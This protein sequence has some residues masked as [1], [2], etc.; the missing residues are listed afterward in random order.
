MLAHGTARRNRSRISRPCVLRPV[1]WASV[2]GH[3]RISCWRL[4]ARRPS[5]PGGL[6][7]FSLCS[8]AKR[9]RPTGSTGVAPPKLRGRAVFKC[10]FCQSF[11]AKV[12]LAPGKSGRQ[13]RRGQCDAG[14][15]CCLCRKTLPGRSASDPPAARGR[16]LSLL[17]SQQVKNGTTSFRKTV[18]AESRS[19]PSE[20]RPPPQHS[21]GRQA[22][23]CCKMCEEMVRNFHKLS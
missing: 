2:A 4:S 22:F 23:G 8:T 21:F 1:P 19:V 6:A 12:T 5:R 13:A 7:T 10:W 16:V 20:D 17:P 11:E 15:A 9:S 18:L 14:V 3:R